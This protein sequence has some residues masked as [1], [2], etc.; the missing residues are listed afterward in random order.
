[1]A[2][3]NRGVATFSIGLVGPPLSFGAKLVPEHQMT[4]GEVCY[5]ES[6]SFAVTS[7]FWVFSPVPVILDTSQK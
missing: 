7:L 5:H 4:H 3:Q 1:M 6:A 2:G